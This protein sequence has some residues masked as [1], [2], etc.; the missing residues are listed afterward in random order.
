MS[1][2]FASVT[3]FMGRS[4]RLGLMR[5]VSAIYHIGMA[6]LLLSLPAVAL[7][8]LHLCGSGI[9]FRFHLGLPGLWMG[10]V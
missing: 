4:F 6:R 2:N 10:G 8:G 7:L 5:V 9:F 3:L 1:T